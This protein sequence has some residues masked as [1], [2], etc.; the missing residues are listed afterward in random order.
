MNKLTQTLL[1]G[2]ALCALVAA[3]VMAQP[4]H[5]A[6]RVTALHAGHVVNKTTF[7]S[8]GRQHVT[9]TFG[10]YTSIQAVLDKKVPVPGSF[11]KWNSTVSG[12]YTLCSTPKE[13]VKFDPK[14]TLYG[15][16]SVATE[17]YSFGCPSGPA[18]FYGADYKLTTAGGFGQTDHFVISEIGWFQA[19]GN[20]YKGTL[21]LDLSATIVK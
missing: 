19:N 8:P 5:P 21:N 16:L 20:K 14:K 10:G 1:T 13:K 2:T 12:S 4:T 6:M 9:Y 15:K 17:T 7:H 18:T 11:Y 3:P